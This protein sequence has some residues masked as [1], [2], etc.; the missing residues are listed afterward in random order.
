MLTTTVDNFPAHPGIQGPELMQK[1][2][3]HATLFGAE[4]LENYVESIDIGKKPFE[5]TV[6]GAKYLAR[7]VI[8]AT[9]ASPIIPAISGVEHSR[10]ALAQDVLLGRRNAGD[11]VLVVGG[12]PIGLET[13]E[14]LDHKGKD[15]TLIEM[16][17][18]VGAGMGPTVRWNLLHR[19]KERGLVKIFTST[20]IEK[21]GEQDVTVTTHE[22]TETWQ[23]F[24]IIVLAVGI[25][26]QN[27]IADQISSKVKELHLIG[28]AAGPR[29]GVDA[30]R[31][32]ALIGLSI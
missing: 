12:G 20:K 7:T 18:R 4:F 28:D 15:V 30:M 5:V 21:I 9:G 14:F 19:M 31:E 3:D 8:V 22:K 1:M 2:R 10:V 11:H 16:L 26:A 25:K 17:G 23:R 13:A 27:Q 6:A 29:K 32:G 24:D